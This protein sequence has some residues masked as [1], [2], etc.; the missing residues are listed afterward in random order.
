M[1]QEIGREVKRLREARGWSQAKLAVEAQMSVSG[2]S[3]IENGRRNLS[4]ATLAKLAEAL[5]VEVSDLFPKAQA[6][7]PLEDEGTG[8]AFR[9]YEAVANTRRRARRFRFDGEERFD[10]AFS[11]FEK[12]R[13]AAKETGDPTQAQ[14]YLDK[15]SSILREG[16]DHELALTSAYFKSA[17]DE[18]LR[19]ELGE[20]WELNE[21]MRQILRG[22]G[23]ESVTEEEQDSAQGKGA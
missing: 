9:A 1:D 22:L 23:G 15:A 2:V 21:K 8:G 4:T 10:H 6:P 7:L 19:A 3:Q 12:A 5:D 18:V 13:E 16:V 17:F 20:A 11:L 14:L